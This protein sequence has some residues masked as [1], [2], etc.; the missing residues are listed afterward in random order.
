M[1]YGKRYSKRRTPAATNRKILS[2]R[3]S[4]SNQKYQILSLNKKIN[5]ISRRVADTTYKVMNKASLSES[6]FASNAYVYNL[7]NIP[8]WTSVFGETDNTQ[9]GGKYKSS[10]MTIDFAITTGTETESVVWTLFICTPKTQKVAEEADSGSGTLSVLSDGKDFTMVE[11]KALM[12]LKRWNVHY[13]TR[14]ATQP[15]VTEAQSAV[16]TVHTNFVNEVKPARRYIDIKNPNVHV[17]NRDGLWDA[18]TPAKMNHNQRY[19]AMLFNNNASTL[20]GSPKFS[21]TV[22]HTG[23]VSQ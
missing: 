4:A 22:L 12:N 1:A 23:V 17:V 14:G 13:C 7:C 19:T 5:R 15:I 3:P 18:V 21:M 8:A 2:K 9:E 16:P 10:R 11:G 20:E 6:N